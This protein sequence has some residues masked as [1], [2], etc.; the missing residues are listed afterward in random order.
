MFTK[1]PGRNVDARTG[2]AGVCA[3]VCFDA[4]P[5]VHTTSVD[6]YD[7]M[8]QPHQRDPLAIAEPAL[9]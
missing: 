3:L 2:R 6:F 7:N 1:V 4:R 5:L 9:F 8:K